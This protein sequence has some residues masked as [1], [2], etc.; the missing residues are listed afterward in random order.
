MLID[1][2][3]ENYIVCNQKI[4]YWFNFV[5]L[6]YN[7]Q[8]AIHCVYLMLINTTQHAFW[9][10]GVSETTSTI[11]VIIICY[12]VLAIIYISILNSNSKKSIFYVGITITLFIWILSL[13]AFNQFLKHNLNH[14]QLIFKS[15]FLSFFGIN[16]VIGVDGL[17]LCF[18]M[19]TTFLMPLCIFASNAIK[20]NYKLFI[21]YILIIELCLIMSFI[22][23]DLLLFYIFFESVLIPMFLIIGQ[24]G[25]KA[26]KIKAAYYL[27]FYTLFGSFFLLFAI[28]YL[29]TLIGTT[30]FDQILNFD[31]L[32]S[33]N[34]SNHT[35][36]LWWLLF[37]PFAIKIPMFP[38]HIWLAEA[39]VEAPTIGSVILASLLLKLGGYGMLRMLFCINGAYIWPNS[40]AHALALTGIIFGSLSTIR[41][42]DLKRI[43]AYSSIAHMN[44]IV[45][46]IFSLTKQGWDG[47][48]YLMVGHA[49][50]SSALFFSIG[51]LYA[52]YHTRL[53]KYY[54][55]LTQTMP[56]FSVLFFIFTL[57]NISFP[58]TSNFIGELLIFLSIPDIQTVIEPLT[59]LVLTSTTIVLSAVYSI[60]LYNRIFF[61][62]LKQ[63]FIRY[64]RDITFNEIIILSTKSLL[65][66][67]FG[68][69]SDIILLWTNLSFLNVNVYEISTLLNT[70]YSYI[71]NEIY[72]Q[73]D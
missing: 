9:N 21:Q 37:V 30:N 22:S 41:Q 35:K 71:T 15:S 33:T 50:V 4:E 20:T 39:H 18:L 14:F 68:L 65:I 6:S 73:N 36:Y 23:L 3:L 58:G 16:F 34:N 51:I 17:S 26:R 63:N 45:L 43:V 46:G 38:C 1:H 29:Y 25:S 40:I 42:I 24:W 47:A 69:N 67:V 11:L 10:A 49:F 27:F 12:N 19:L 72:I 61:G 13:I 31:I 2:I 8:F 53:L 57:A 62:S 52:R 55:G 70:D 56:I 64:Y 32:I 44:L 66:I 60:W 54:G 5:F 28:L 59:L 48:L 7:L